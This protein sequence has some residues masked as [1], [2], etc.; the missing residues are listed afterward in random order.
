MDAYAAIETGRFEQ[1]KILLVMA[2]RWNLI[3]SLHRFFF[4]HL[5]FVKFLIDNVSV[6]R[7]V[8]LDDVED[9]LELLDFCANV[10]F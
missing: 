6:G 8:L 9:G 1:P 5:H 4:L 3:W 2:A 10:V 7:D